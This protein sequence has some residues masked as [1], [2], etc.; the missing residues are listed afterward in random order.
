MYGGG[1]RR[2]QINIVTRGVEIIIGEDKELKW[3]KKTNH[4]V[5]ELKK[6]PSI[7][8]NRNKL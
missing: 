2:E 8:I 1:N 5:V 6:L 4:S 7:I 3:L